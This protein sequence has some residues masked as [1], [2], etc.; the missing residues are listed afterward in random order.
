M[1]AAAGVLAQDTGLATPTL[2]N[3][4]DAVGFASVLVGLSQIGTRRLGR[5]V[6]VRLITGQRG[7]F[8]WEDCKVGEMLADRRRGTFS[9]STK[10]DTTTTLVSKTPGAWRHH[11]AGCVAR[12]RSNAGAPT[13]RVGVAC[14]ATDS[15]HAHRHNR[16]Q[17]TAAAGVR[18]RPGDLIIADGSG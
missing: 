11:H 2:A 13:A 3:T 8:R 18:V 15:A 16:H 9:S 4:L 17:R 12:S 5:A 6:T 7:H 10:P 14:D 1:P